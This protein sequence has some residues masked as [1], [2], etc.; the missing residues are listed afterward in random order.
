MYDIDF[1]G[2]NV[3]VVGG[4]SGIGNGIARAFLEKGAKV[5]VWGTRPSAEDYRDEPGSDLSGVDY[6]CLD[7]SDHAAV[8]DYSP[9]FDTLNVLVLCQGAVTYGRREFEHD[10]WMRVSTINLHSVMDC[11]TKFKPLLADSKGSIIVVSSVAGLRSS[12]G[13]PAYASSKAGA[14]GLTRT[15]GEAWAAQGVRVNGIAPGFVDTKLTKV[16]TENPK[17]LAAMLA[18]IPLRRLGDPSDM[19]GV[20]LFLASPLAGYIIGETLVVDGG[21]SNRS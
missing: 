17:R 1:T 20:A 18:N 13:N 9:P 10:E 8:R 15:L 12:K 7:V 11:A 2:Q 14:I 6:A 19:A 4:S 5:F 3:L 21:Y 16:T